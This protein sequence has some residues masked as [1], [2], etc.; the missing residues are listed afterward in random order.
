[1]CLEGVIVCKSEDVHLPLCSHYFL[2]LS[3]VLSVAFSIVCYSNKFIFI[4]YNL[5]WYRICTP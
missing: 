1:M 4:K 5:R 3:N 2:T